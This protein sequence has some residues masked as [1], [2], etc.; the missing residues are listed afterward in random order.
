MLQLEVVFNSGHRSLALLDSGA[1]ANF[2]DGDFVRRLNL[3]VFPLAHR[4]RAT[5]AS[6]EV[7]AAITSKVIVDLECNGLR[8]KRGFFVYPK[9]S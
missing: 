8:F 7:H 1:T 6:V 9:T 4:T 5:L 3:P 2:I